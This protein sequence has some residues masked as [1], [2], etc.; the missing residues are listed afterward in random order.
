V[1]N[2]YSVIYTMTT[3]CSCTFS[4][5]GSSVFQF[6]LHKNLNAFP[7]VLGVPNHTSIHVTPQKEITYVNCSFAGATLANNIYTLLSPVA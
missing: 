7:R 5:G 6:T 1:S 2:Q 3:T 4:N